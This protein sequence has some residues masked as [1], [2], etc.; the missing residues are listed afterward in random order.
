MRSDALVLFGATGDLAY[1]QIFPALQDL[2]RK[3]GFD[4]PI[5]GVADTA[6]DL[7]GLRAR[8]LDSL[9]AAGAVDVAAYARLA[10]RL[11]YVRGDYRDEATYA[12]LRQAL[13]GAERPLFYMAI[14]PTMFA[15]VVARLRAA[16]LTANARI[17][18]EKPF[19]R[20]LASARA[21]EQ[22]LRS[23]FPDDAIFRIDHF[24]GKEPVMNLFYLRFANA[25]VE[26]LWNR[27]YIES[28]QITMAESFGVRSRGR[29]YEE[30]GAIRDVIQNHLLQVAASIA[31]AAPARGSTVRDEAGR[32]LR[33]VVPIDRGSV[34]RGQYRGYREEPG[35][36]PGSRVETF[37]AV[38][39][40]VDSWRWAGV[41]FYLR[42]GKALATTATE[43]WVAMR[44][45]PRTPFGE[46]TA[47]PCNYVRFRLGPDVT[48][49]IGVR[50][51]VLG[52]RMVGEPIELVPTRRRGTGT[53]PYAR[54]LDDAMNGDPMLF[55]TWEAIEAQWQIV[56]PILGDVTP[57]YEYDRGT[58]G[59]PEL[60]R[61]LV[62]PIG[63]RNPQAPPPSPP[64]EPASAPPAYAG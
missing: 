27:T 53:R 9:Q 18:I 32:L 62:P 37:A 55:A 60:E 42:A 3:G 15:I 30:T 41:P 59:P 14:P 34:V 58:W 46:R 45:P 44:C 36:A 38:R 31:L 39:L 43:V 57:L 48:T 51:K 33:A 2:A 24:L 40:F 11:R 61:A 5:V 20:D 12:S 10:A 1:R 7:E 50:S 19:G 54:L 17:M 49:A 64:E 26:P 8:V 63:W 35:V 22:A 16:G 52:E 56:E 4:A 29:F 23:A 28:V 21:L 47:T 25:I 6:L 13:A